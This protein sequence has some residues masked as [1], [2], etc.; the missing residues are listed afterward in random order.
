MFFVLFDFVLL[1][2]VI[3]FVSV[4]FVCWHINI[5]WVVSHQE[6]YQDK[7]AF[8]DGTRA[9]FFREKRVALI[10]GEAL[11]RGYTIIRLM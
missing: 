1:F 2:V 5:M 4:D 6:Y 9:N 3:P 11:I 10:R 7:I 8:Y